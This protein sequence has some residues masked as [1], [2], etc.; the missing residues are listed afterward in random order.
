MARFGFNRLT[1]EAK[2]AL[3]RYIAPSSQEPQEGQLVDV[4]FDDDTRIEKLPDGR[5]IYLINQEEVFVC[6]QGVLSVPESWE[7]YTRFRDRLLNRAPY[8]QKALI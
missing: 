6:S 5:Y 3:Q 2:E 4:N 8:T 7:E 1:E